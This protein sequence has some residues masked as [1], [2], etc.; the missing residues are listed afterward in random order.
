MIVSDRVFDL[1]VDSI[2]S[3]W[4]TGNISVDFDLPNTSLSGKKNK[5]W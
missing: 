4:R 2:G 5:K 3:T 1:M